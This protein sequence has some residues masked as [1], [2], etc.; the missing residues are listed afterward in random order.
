[1]SDDSQLLANYA[2]RGD[3]QSLAVL[4]ERHS[5]GMF[6]ILRGMLPSEAD[7]QDAL[8]DAW[9]RVVRAAGKFRGGEVRAYLA[10]VARSAAIDLMRRRG[11]TVSLDAGGEGVEDEV[12]EQVATEPLP[13]EAFESKADAEEVR[14]AVQSL[15]LGPRQVLLLRMEGE[16]TFR[17]IAE[18]LGV[19]LGTALTWMRLATKNLR[20]ILVEGE[21]R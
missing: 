14:L 9:H 7:A 1:M 5:R 17:E 19:P 4:V 16:L 12:A 3:V 21:G 2:R 10:K 18:T 13:S 8:Q 15:P 11:R 6:A 20:K